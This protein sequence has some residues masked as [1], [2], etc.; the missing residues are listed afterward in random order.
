MT[1]FA[2]NLAIAV[3]TSAADGV[4]ESRYAARD[5]RLTADP[6]AV[7]WK[8]IAG[9]VTSNGRHGE[10]IPGSRTEVRSR[11]T[12]RHLYFL[13]IAQYE[14]MHLTPSPS[15][16][17]ET[18]GLWEYDV[19]EVF[20]G[21]DREHIRRYKEFEVSPQGEW[22]DL[23]VD[24]DRSAKAVDWVWDSGFRSRTR[25]DAANKIW[26]CEMQIPWKSIDP[27]RPAAG[28]ELRLNLYRIEGAPPNRKYIAW[29]LVNGPSFHAPESFGVLRLV[30]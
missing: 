4:L 5:A 18:W 12:K 9:V 20:I 15:T 28:A 13:F 26:Y 7:L 29:R 6:Q 24:R 11:W 8:D 30:N 10:P 3:L 14:S 25:V 22:V 17:K 1:I 16:V 21:W 19:A 23:D 2:L 27:R